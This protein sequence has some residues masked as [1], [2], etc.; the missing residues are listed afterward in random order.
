MQQA[1]KAGLTSAVITT[2]MSVVPEVYKA[3]D[4][5]ITNGEIDEKQF[6]R[7]GFAAVTGSSLGFVRGVVSAAI[8][9]GCQ[10]GFLGKPLMNVSP[11][12]VGVDVYKRQTSRILDG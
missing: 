3:I 1:F 7:I 8:T 2:V 4:Y 6:R 11:S 10:A 9:I 5:L 12:L